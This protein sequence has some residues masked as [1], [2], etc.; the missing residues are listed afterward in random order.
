MY[1]FVSNIMFYF[2]K[3]IY[4]NKIINNITNVYAQIYKQHFYQQN[5][6]VMLFF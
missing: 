1:Y 3:Y 4:Y 2:Y 6:I 5:C